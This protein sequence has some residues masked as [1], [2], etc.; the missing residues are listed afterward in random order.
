MTLRQLL[1]DSQHR[2]VELSAEAALDGN[3]AW[4]EAQAELYQQFGQQIKALWDNGQKAA[5]V[6]TID[7]GAPSKPP[8]TKRPHRL[9]TASSTEPSSSGLRRSGGSGT[10]TRGQTG[11]R[12]RRSRRSDRLA[13]GGPWVRLGAIAFAT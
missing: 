6:P 10:R 11:S 9:T 2:T 1:R 7:P 8:R 3:E 13:H 4:G 12:V 5:E